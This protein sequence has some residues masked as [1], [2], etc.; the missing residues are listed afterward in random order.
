MQ[1]E[2]SAS[3]NIDLQS[4]EFAARVEANQRELTGNLRNSYDFIV[5]GS[6][7]SGCV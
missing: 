3:S 1:H 2:T 5:C 4:E 7:S 6:G